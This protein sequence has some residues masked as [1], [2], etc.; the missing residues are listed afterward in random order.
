MEAD[1]ESEL[2]LEPVGPDSR[3][4][5]RRVHTLPPTGSNAAWMCASTC[6]VTRHESMVSPSGVSPVVESSQSR[7]MS[8]G[9]GIGS[10]IP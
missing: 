6:R 10:S 9:I 2:Y 7:P 3:H 1:A 5:E 4:Q 8:F